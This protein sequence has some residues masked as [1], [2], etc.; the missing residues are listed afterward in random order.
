MISKFKESIFELTRPMPLKRIKNW[1]EYWKV[2]ELAGKSRAKKIAPYI[3]IGSTVLDIGCGDGSLLE[4]LK[5]I[6]NIEPYGIDISEIAVRK[7]L[8]R[9][10]PAKRLDITS[11]NFNIKKRYDYIILAE[12]IEH[13]QNAEEVI[14]K[15]RYNFDKALIITIPNIGYILHRCRLLFGRFPTA[16]VVFHT[17]EHVRHWTISDFKYWISSLGLEVEEI[18]PISPTKL[19][20]FEFGNL[21]PSLFSVSIAYIIKRIDTK[22]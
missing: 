10:I 9:G 8:K 13:I 3:D 22:R 11:Q 21:Y 16:N 5:E 1:D 15:I 18:I 6:K 4:T 19:F 2:A 20:G 17:R 12:V 7:T 14:E